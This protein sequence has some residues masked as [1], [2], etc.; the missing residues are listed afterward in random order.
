MYLT[1]N[2]TT[3]TEIWLFI[4]NTLLCKDLAKIVTMPIQH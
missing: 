2:S 1:Y 3:A 4:R